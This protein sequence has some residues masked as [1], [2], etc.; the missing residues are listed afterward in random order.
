LAEVLRQGAADI[1]DDAAGV[2]GQHQA[3][4]FVRV[5]LG[6]RAR[7]R[8]YEQQQRGQSL[9]YFDPPHDPNPLPLR[10]RVAKRS[11]PGEGPSSHESFDLT[12]SPA[13]LASA[14]SAPSPTRG[15]GTAA[16]A[17][18]ARGFH[19]LA[20]RLPC[21]VARIASQSRGLTAR[22]AESG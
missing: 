18:P 11:E 13:S 8:R 5:G 7:Y 21:V 9:H 12:P 15:E 14:R 20:S 17:M 6:R 19:P 10:E 1:I 2:V 16:A 22:A 3:N 4:G